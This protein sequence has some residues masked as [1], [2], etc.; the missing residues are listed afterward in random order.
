MQ[1]AE[2]TGK[3]MHDLP[4]RL[5]GGTAAE[6]FRAAATRGVAFLT[7]SVLT[8]FLLL[9]GPRLAHAGLRQVDDPDRR[10]RVRVLLLSAYDRAFGYARGSLIMAFAAGAIAYVVAYVADVPGA[11]PLALWVGLW[12]VVPFIGTAVGAAPI[13][14]LA[15]VESPARG[16]LLAVVFL[17]YQVFE[18]LL[19]QP[20]L[21][22]KTMR[23]GPFLTVVAGFAGLELRG[24]TGALIAVL[25]VA[26][27]VAVLDELA[28]ETHGR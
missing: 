14:L 11:A 9:H 22:D 2:R 23:L 19:L 16:A 27:V 5:R 8:L 7:T 13:V 20:R 26:T 24:L 15:A 12:D 1:L 28:P 25:A 3:F 18:G 21:E 10:E 17:G 6:A 4:S